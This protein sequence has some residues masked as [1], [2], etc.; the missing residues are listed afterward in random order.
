MEKGE[1]RKKACDDL[2]KLDKQEYSLNNLKSIQ[3]EQSLNLVVTLQFGSQ[4][5]RILFGCD[6]AR[7]SFKNTLV[8]CVDGI[9]QFKDFNIYET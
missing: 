6:N 9:D 2:F 7:E 3:M 4:N 5:L 1:R 8:Q